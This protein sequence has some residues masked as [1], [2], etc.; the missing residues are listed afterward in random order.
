MGEEDELGVKV[1]ATKADDLSSIPGGPRRWQKRTDSSCPLI[2]THRME[3]T[4]TH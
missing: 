4:P 1:L 2:S 3:R